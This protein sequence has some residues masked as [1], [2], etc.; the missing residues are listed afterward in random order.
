MIIN[1]IL[2]VEVESSGSCVGL[3]P[4]HAVRTFTIT[5]EKS[6]KQLIVYPNI[7]IVFKPLPS[8]TSELP[9]LFA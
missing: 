2:L 6:L 8:H 7:L 3:L 1:I 5:P 9:D 4:L